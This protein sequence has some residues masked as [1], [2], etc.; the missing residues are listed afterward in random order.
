MWGAPDDFVESDPLWGVYRFKEGF[1]GRVMRHLGAW[2]YTSRS[3]LY[4]LYTRTLP[5][6]LDVMRARGKAATQRK[7]AND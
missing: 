2:D 6:I 4:R 1:N 3:G 5:K 7:L